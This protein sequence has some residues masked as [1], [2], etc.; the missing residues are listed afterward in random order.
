MRRVL[1][2]LLA[3]ASFTV[4][5]LALA[6][7]VLDRV[8]MP[9]LVL[10]GSERVVPDVTG[11]D[12]TRARKTLVGAGFRAAVAGTESHPTLPK[13][14]VV[15]QEPY[16]LSRAKPSRTVKLT[17]SAGPASVVVPRLR[18][19]GCR[20]S[21]SALEQAGLAIGDILAVQTSWAGAGQ[22]VA[23]WPP[24]GREVVAG[25]EVHLLLSAPPQ[26]PCFV[27]PSFSGRRIDEVTRIL[28]E[29]GISLGG[30]TFVPGGS[31]G[32]VI[33]TDPPAGSKVCGGETVAVVVWAG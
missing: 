14:V 33:S 10:S 28:R 20:E 7:L 23:L 32:T 26:P 2:F 24:P 25:T 4:I 1:G 13:G 8:V 18:G 9:R 30:R 17:V 6:L 21:V 11:M 27:L 12:A 5:L 15:A 3:Y 16:P 19:L 31:E 22:V 29:H